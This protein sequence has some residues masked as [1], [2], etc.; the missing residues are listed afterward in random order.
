M[1]CGNSKQPAETLA[2]E[3]AGAVKKT[4]GGADSQSLVVASEGQTPQ[5]QA[6]AHGSA[7]ADPS[8]S[9]PTTEPENVAPNRVRS[10]ALS[11]GDLS[12]AQSSQPV[13]KAPS[14][15]K[16]VPLES[17]PSTQLDTSPVTIAAGGD[18][19]EV[20][21]RVFVFNPNAPEIHGTSGIVQK[22]LSGQDAGRVL[23]V[24]T[25]GEKLNI[26]GY[27]LYV[28]ECGCGINHH[29]PDAGPPQAGRHTHKFEDG[30]AYFGD[31]KDGKRC[32]VPRCQRVTQIVSPRDRTPRC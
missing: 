27:N 26:K 15:Y 28:D 16:D 9:M 29:T 24:T 2:F 5:A 23:L 18:G 11:P 25:S 1:G 20:G 22:L 4:G 12:A 6:L 30:T 17:A 10:E 8:A 3:P 14:T 21:S 31:F 7:P 19:L 13:S 32:S